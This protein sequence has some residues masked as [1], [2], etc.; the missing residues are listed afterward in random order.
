MLSAGAVDVVSGVLLL[1]LGPSVLEP[2]LYLDSQKNDSVLL[3][4]D[5]VREKMTRGVRK[6][7]PRPLHASR[8]PTPDQSNTYPAASPWRVTRSHRV[9]FS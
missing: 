9:K 3:I 7:T 4:A 8:T 6:T 5:V 1:P 2:D